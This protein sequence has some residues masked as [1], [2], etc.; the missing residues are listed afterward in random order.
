MFSLYIKESQAGL[1][2]FIFKILLNDFF[3]CWQEMFD[4]PM[5]V[6]QILKLRPLQINSYWN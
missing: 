5:H 6:D 1:A 2:Y 4:L 3:S